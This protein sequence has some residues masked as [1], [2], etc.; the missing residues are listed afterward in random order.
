MC[1]KLYFLIYTMVILQSCGQDN[2]TRTYRLPKSAVPPQVENIK[3]TQSSIFSWKKPDSW[4]PSSGSS[5]RIA[6]FEIPY[7]GGMG[8]LSVIQLGGKGGG[9]EPNINRW[10]KQL[11]LEPQSLSEIEKDIIKQKG[12]LGEYKMIKIVNT[13]NNLAFLAAII[14]VENQTLFVK[15]SANLSGIK[16][17]E[18]D[19]VSFCSSIHFAH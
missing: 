10:R 9:F 2:H 18:L 1:L 4:I 19:F 5:M 13:Q 17:A 11:N 14:P 16:K 15:L 3:K 6:S 7:I 8:D 12:E